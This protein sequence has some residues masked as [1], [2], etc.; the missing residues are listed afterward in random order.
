MA[1]H[2]N[3]PFTVEQ[4]A[5]I[6]E[7]A[8]EACVAHTVAKNKASAEWYRQDANRIRRERGMVTSDGD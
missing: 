6:R 1:R 2:A 5:R 8:T 7:I 4:E 3:Q